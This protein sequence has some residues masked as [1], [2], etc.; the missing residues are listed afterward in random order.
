MA[1]IYRVTITGF[2]FGQMV[3]NRLHFEGPDDN[4]IDGVLSLANQIQLEWIP[5]IRPAINNECIFQSIK[6]DEVGSGPIAPTITNQIAI[7][8]SAGTDAAAP[9]FFAVVLQLATESHGRNQHGR[10]MMPAQSPGQFSN[11]VMNSLGQARWT[12]PVNTLRNRWLK[13]GAN[14]TGEFTLCLSTAPHG[15]DQ[16]REVKNIILRTLPGTQNSRKMGVGS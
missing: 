15:Q 9:P 8:G 16:V 4:A 10:I 2:H 11:G 12:N 13:N 6:V 1:R 7:P 5:T 3:Q 14:V